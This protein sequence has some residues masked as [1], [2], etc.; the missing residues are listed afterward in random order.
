MPGSS[1]PVRQR[2]QRRNRQ[3]VEQPG[4]KQQRVLDA[5]SQ[6]KRHA[7]HPEVQVDHGVLGACGNDDIIQPG[8]RSEPSFASTRNF[9]GSADAFVLVDQLER[10]SHAGERLAPHAEGNG[11][12]ALP[13]RAE[14]VS[15]I[16][17]PLA[18]STQSAADTNANK[19]GLC[20]HHAAPGSTGMPVLSLGVGQAVRARGLS[21]AGCLAKEERRPPRT[22]SLRWQKA[23]DALSLL[24]HDLLR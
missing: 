15:G 7:F 24:R 23:P 9:A 21:R 10:S 20:S 17:L 12:P 2:A 6:R 14:A 18:R 11:S 5:V 4:G 8:L 3:L 16:Q 22:L 1:L 19:L 13:G